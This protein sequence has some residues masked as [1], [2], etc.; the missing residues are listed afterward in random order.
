MA[1]LPIVT[2][3]DTRLTVASTPVAA[4]TPEILLLVNDMIDTLHAHRALG[5]AAVQVGHLLRIFVVDAKLAKQ[6]HPLV[7]INPTVRMTG[8]GYRVGAEGCL[9][10]PGIEAAIRRPRTVK[11]SAQDQEGR[12]FTMSASGLRARCILHEFDHVEGRLMI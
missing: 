9:S 3:P 1:V 2:W 10:F 12:T 11:I 7:F 4:V 8:G 5:L 6:P